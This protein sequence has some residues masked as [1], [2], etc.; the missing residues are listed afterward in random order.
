M[1]KLQALFGLGITLTFLLTACAGTPSAATDAPTATLIS[2]VTEPTVPTLVPIQLSGPG[3]GA[4]MSWMD[5]GLL[6]AI[7]DD[8]AGFNPARPGTGRSLGLASMRERIRLVNGT[9]DIESAPGKGTA[10]IARVP[11]EGKQ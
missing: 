9:L 11:V 7:R 1:K 6:L 3:A 4:V 5:G 2:I 8:G 10:I